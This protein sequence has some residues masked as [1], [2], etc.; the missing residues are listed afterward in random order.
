VAIKSS[1]DASGADAA[2]PPYDGTDEPIEQDQ[3]ED[4]NDASFAA[5]TAADDDDNDDD[6]SD[7]AKLALEMMESCWSILD[8][9]VASS[10]AGGGDGTGPAP[11]Y[12]TWAAE[13]VPR[14]LTGLGD[15]LSHRNRHA[16]A[17]DAYL[18]ALEH[19]QAALDGRLGDVA[20]AKALES[21]GLSSSP[22]AGSGGL[23]P[24]DQSRLVDLLTCRRKLV[25][26]NVLVAEEL[27]A[28]VEVEGADRDVVTSETGAVL[29]AAGE[30]VDSARFYYESS[31]D[32]L[33]EAVLLLGQLA[34][35]LPGGRH[36]EALDEEKE[37]VC[38]VA[39]LV[40]GV[41][42]ALAALDEQADAQ[43]PPAAKRL[44]S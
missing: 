12:L 24:R 34:A 4:P 27:L 10:P 22:S 8:Q 18:R 38:Y 36:R 41:G 33:Q 39:T 44:K 13:Q 7:D 21:A 15:V 14:V 23:A 19:R 28:H 26:T 31:R 9:Y 40:M 29:V 20:T 2:S 11:R 30:R 5:A 6:E 17:A 1:G 42:E 43:K 3:D 37:N 32:Q 35:H 25:E 16:D